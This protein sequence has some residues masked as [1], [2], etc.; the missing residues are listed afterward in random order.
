ME[1][2]KDTVSVVI[3]TMSG[4][5]NFLDRCLFILS[6]QTYRHIEPVIILQKRSHDENISEIGDVIKRWSAYFDSIELVSHFADYDA[7]SKSL[8]IGMNKSIGQYLAFLDDDDKVYPGHFELLVNTLKATDFSWAYCDVVM[9]L[10]NKHGQLISRT[11]PFKKNAYS[12]LD[13]LKQNFI[14]IHSFLIDRYRA[15]EL[16]LVNEKFSKNEDYEFILRLAAKHEPLYVP[17]TGVEYCVR[18]DGTNTI[19]PGTTNGRQLRQKKQDWIVAEALLSKAK[20][21]NFGWWIHEV[22]EINAFNPVHL[23]H[24][25]ISSNHYRRLLDEIRSTISWRVGWKI[26]K[27]FKKILF[28]KEE[29]LF[30]PNSEEDAQQEIN[31]TLQSKIWK[32]TKPVRIARRIHSALVTDDL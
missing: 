27:Y 2:K 6:G 31:R 32:L 10:Y 16:G 14:P 9:G 23:P 13:H 3:R 15:S 1:L 20:E 26:N 17:V 29:Q 25:I 12:F 28:L 4:R 19:L 11:W 18:E 24:P 22:N 7:R 8:N 21:E 5:S 30:Y